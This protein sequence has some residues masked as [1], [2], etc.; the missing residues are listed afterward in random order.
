MPGLPVPPQQPVQKPQ[1]F[2]LVDPHP[3]QP[4]LP[5]SVP[6][7]LQNST[8]LHGPVHASAS[9]RRRSSG[10]SGT[11]VTPSALRRT[12]PVLARTPLREMEAK[13]ST[14]SDLSTG[15][16]VVFMLRN[17]PSR[18]FINIAACHSCL[19][20]RSLQ[21]FSIQDTLEV[22]QIVNQALRGKAARCI[23]KQSVRR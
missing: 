1:L 14:H 7:I 2:M 20:T 13:R 12:L 4:S 15:R 3:G 16:S 23:N 5:Q 9:G 6:S 22:R 21:F 11:I 18:D 17:R 8:P 10:R 19:N